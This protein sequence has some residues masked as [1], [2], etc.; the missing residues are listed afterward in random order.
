L[1]WLTLPALGAKLHP[2]SLDQQLESNLF[3]ERMWFCFTK[4]GD[5]SHSP[6]MNLGRFVSPPRLILLLVAQGRT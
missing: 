3:R 1:A 6:K 2:P 4:E 5:A